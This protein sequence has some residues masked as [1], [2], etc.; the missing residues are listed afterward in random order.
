MTKENNSPFYRPFSALQMKPS[1]VDLKIEANE[2]ERG[3]IAADFGLP[4]IRSLKSEFKLTGRPNRI[5]VVGVIHAD[6]QQICVVSLEPFDSIVKEEI[7]LVFS[8]EDRRRSQKELDVAEDT[9]EPIVNGQID[10]G[11]VT[12]EFLALGLDPYPR[13]PGISFEEVRKVL[14][15]GDDVSAS[16]G[17]FAA[18][19]SKGSP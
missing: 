1:G 8:E 11:A 7:E 12:L 5:K 14:G 6:I 3:T 19:K 16:L 15:L 18:D 2:I 9:A 17:D 13:K 4:E 10:F